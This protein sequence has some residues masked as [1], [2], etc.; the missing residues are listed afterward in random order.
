MCKCKTGIHYSKRKWLNP[1]GH[2]ASAS[3]VA[4]SGQGHWEE[5]GERAIWTFLEIADC[6]GKVRLHKAQF[7]TME[8]YTNKLALLRDEIDRFIKHLKGK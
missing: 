2:S 7:D 6:H 3:V 4:Y 1:D 5:H 8:D